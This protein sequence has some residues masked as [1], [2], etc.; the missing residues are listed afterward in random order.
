MF[1]KLVTMFSLFSRRK[2]NPGNDDTG[3]LSLTTNILHIERVIG[4]LVFGAIPGLECYFT[5]TVFATPSR[6]R[7]NSQVNQGIDGGRISR[8]WIS[9]SAEEKE[10]SVLYDMGEWTAMPTTAKEKT[11]V[12]VLLRSW[13]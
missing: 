8:L 2:P 13:A 3:N 10:P 4:N 7:Y 5:A 12:A 9:E 11:A 1:N 6:D